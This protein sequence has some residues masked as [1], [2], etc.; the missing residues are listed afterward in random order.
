MFLKEIY[1]N[2]VAYIK[3]TFIIVAVPERGGRKVGT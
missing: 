3:Y 2:V 1:L